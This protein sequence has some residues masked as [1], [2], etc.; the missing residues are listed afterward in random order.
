MNTQNNRRFQ[1]TD[2]AIIREVYRIMWEEKRPVSKIT[3]RE[4]CEKTGINR[5][6][7][8]AHYQDVFDVAER[9]EY[10]MAKMAGEAFMNHLSGENWIRAG[11]IKL[12]EFIREYRE[13][14]LLYLE[15]S[16]RMRAIEMLIEPHEEKL[17]AASPQSLGFSS[18]EEMR[19][20]QDFFAAGIAALLYRWLKNGCRETP[21]ELYEIV[22]KHGAFPYGTLE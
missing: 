6:T 15:E 16:R 19:Y 11:F 4:V 9:V 13:F 7:F 20:A 14:Y 22:R 5:S 21:E 8:Y 1:N 12:F 17:K 2:E 18:W 3:V 10:Q